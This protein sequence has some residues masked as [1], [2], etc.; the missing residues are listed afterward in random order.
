[1]E[2]RIIIRHLGA[3]AK[4][5]E[6][7]VE[8]LVEVIFGREEGCTV[9]FDPG[10]DEMVSRRH[11]KLSLT[12]REPLAIAM[13]DLGSRNGTFVNHHRI[14]GEVRLSPGDR[15]QLGAGGPEFEVDVFPRLDTKEITVPSDIPVRQ[16]APATVAVP[17]MAGPIQRQQAGVPA[18]LPQRPPSSG[19]GARTLMMVCGIALLALG[20]LTLGSWA[21]F[22]RGTGVLSVKVYYQPDVMTVAYKTYGNPAAAKGKYWFAKTVIEN[23]GKGSLRNV[24][25]QY[26]IPDYIPWTTPD[27]V[28][29][30]YPGETVVLVYYPKFPSKVTDIRTQTPATLEVKVDYDGGTEKTHLEKRDFEFRG[31]SE[32]AYTSLPANEILTYYDVFDN[33]PLLASFVTDEDPVVKTFY[34]KVS[35]ASGGINT[36]DEG[37]NMVAMAR[38]VY[39]YMVSLGMT[40]SGAKGV[41]EK[42]GDVNSLV[43]SIRMPRDVIYGN[44]GLCIELAL[45]WCSIGQ[46]AGAKAYLVMIPSHA[47]T[48]LQAGDGSLLPIECTGIGGGAGGNL[49][50]AMTFQ[51]A[52]ESAAHTLQEVKDKGLPLEIMDIQSYQSLGIRPPELENKDLAELSKLLDDR[53]HGDKRTVVVR[54]VVANN[55]GGGGGQVTPPPAPR[56][57]DTGTAMRVWQDP[58]G[59]VAVP[60]PAD[61][62]VN[63]ATIARVRTV[64]PGYEFAAADLSGRASVEVAVF[65]APN[66]A[67][68]L[69]QYS[70]A[71]RRFGVGANLGSPSQQNVNGRAAII[72][73]VTVSGSGGTFAGTLVI[74]PVRGGFVMV[75][76]T[77]AQPGAANWQGIMVRILRG[78]QF[79]A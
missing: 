79:G 2:Q 7:P 19:S 34:A 36:M 44:S 54:T 51:Q 39:D 13:A 78:I 15:V 48:I 62:V 43:Q 41:P 28:A 29:E 14:Q 61:W 67:A 6:F 73:P 26:Q 5:Q 38:S 9:H 16:A 68:V 69:A 60:Y 32:F 3:D 55:R 47:F 72:Y 27:E 24:K 65:T 56:P 76:A 70:A 42:V 12:S 8:S 46:A 30:I 35:E 52:V 22:G 11:A 71:L 66:L 59:V 37:K 21:L 77:A 64:L 40:Y 45:L 74:A 23:T 33:D 31:L 10:R 49:N 57:T 53:R 50:A 75:S 63:A 20:A 17:A 58:N 1:M 25:V 18:Q 4:I